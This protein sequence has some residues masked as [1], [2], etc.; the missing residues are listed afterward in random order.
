MRL[1]KDQGHEV[2]AYH[3]VKDDPVSIKA[4]LET[5]AGNDAVQAIIINGGTGVSKRDSTV[6][7]VSALLEKRLDGFGELFRYLSYKDIGSSAITS[8]A[9]ARVYRGRITLSTPR[10]ASAV[11]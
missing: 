3:L 5:G 11:R 1:L 9:T 7:T 10:S 4:L 2:V 8:R 6:E